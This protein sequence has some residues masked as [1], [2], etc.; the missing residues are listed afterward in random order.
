MNLLLFR[1][2]FLHTGALFV[3]IRTKNTTVSFFGSN[4]L[5]TRCTFIHILTGQC[6]HFHLFNMPTLRTS[7]ISF[8]FFLHKPIITY[9]KTRY[10]SDLFIRGSAYW[11][12]PP[13]N[14][15]PPSCPFRSLQKRRRKLF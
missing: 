6:W 8:S 13:T 14:D 12:R 7:K 1:T 10:Y 2:L 15:S 9:S 11:F 4:H 5:A 3:S